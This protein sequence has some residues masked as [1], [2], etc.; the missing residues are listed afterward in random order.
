MTESHLT[1]RGSCNTLLLTDS[2]WEVATWPSPFIH[3]VD[4]WSGAC[5]EN[6]KEPAFLLLCESSVNLTLVNFFLVNLQSKC[7][8][9][10]PVTSSV[11]A[12]HTL[13]ARPCPDILCLAAFS[14][15][16][17]LWPDIPK[18]FG[19]PSAKKVVRFSF[20]IQETNYYHTR[21]SFTTLGT[22]IHHSSIDC[23]VNETHGWCIILRCVTL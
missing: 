9:F 13:L 6:Y 10:G 21:I 12:L 7:F 18:F 17:T 4:E 1:G 14:L 11:V 3:P 20:Q 22:L 8:L 23:Y 16:T 5:C 19:D 2:E 15:S